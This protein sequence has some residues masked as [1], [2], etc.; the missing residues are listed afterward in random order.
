VRDAEAGS[1]LVDDAERLLAEGAGGRIDF[2]ANRLQRSL[3]DA[4]AQ[5]SPRAVEILVSS[6]RARPQRCG[7]RQDARNIARHGSP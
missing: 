1:R 2:L 7:D 5:L 6:L 3:L 4:I